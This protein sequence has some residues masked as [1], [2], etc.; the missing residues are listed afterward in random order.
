[1]SA[2]ELS[3]AETKR[4]MLELCRFY[5]EGVALLPVSVIGILGM[6]LFL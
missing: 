1:M 5:L 4:Y 6:N 2:E 3:E